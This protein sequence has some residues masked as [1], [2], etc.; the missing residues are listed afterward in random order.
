M[1]RAEA[2]ATAAAATA[3]AAAVASEVLRPPSLLEMV[4]VNVRR[5]FRG[6]A[7]ARNLFGRS[8]NADATTLRVNIA[9]R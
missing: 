8:A 3:D 2:A 6:K 1:S 9:P 5:R 4:K 7:T